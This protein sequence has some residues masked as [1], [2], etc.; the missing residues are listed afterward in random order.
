MFITV[1]ARC[2]GLFHT[3]FNTTVENPD[4]ESLDIVLIRRSRGVRLATRGTSRGFGRMEEKPY[5]GFVIWQLLWS[6]LGVRPLRSALSVLALALQVFLVLLIVGLTSGALS[7]WRTRAEGVGAD[8]IVQPPNS[9]IFFALSSAVM[10][11][12]L[13]DQMTALPAVDEVA[14]VYI[15]VDQKN[16]G[17]VYGIDYPRFSG[18]SNGFTFLSGGPFQQPNQAIADDLAAHSRKL[19]VGQKTILL[20]HEFTISGIVLHGKGARFFVPIK[21]AQDIAGAE[22]RASIFFVRSKGDTEAA[23]SELVKLLPTY[24]IR[25]MAEFS[26]L[27]SSSNLPELKPFIRSFVLLGVII[28]FLVVLL[29]MHTMVFERTRDIGVL[30]AL[31]SSRLEVCGMILGETLVMVGLGVIAGLLCT[32]GIVAILHKTSPTLQIS[33]EGVWIFRAILLTIAGGIAG[34]AYPALRA[35]NNDPVDALAYE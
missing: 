19:R 13:A 3:L 26:T 27:M 20:N 33:I 17:V 22:G 7:D 35:A 4:S 21:T 28:S 9:S 29:T 31:G 8:I 5:K 18:L 6:N 32:Y 24:K 1:F 2:D 30:R 16:L 23:R 10:P 25:S 11:E 34:A 14:A 12:S 15:V